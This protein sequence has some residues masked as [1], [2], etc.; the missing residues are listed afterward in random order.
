MPT[1]F[2]L[3]QIKATGF[4]DK[5]F[6]LGFDDWFYTGILSRNRNLFSSQQIGGVIVLS[7]DKRSITWVSLLES[8]IPENGIDIYKLLDYLKEEFSMHTSKSDILEKI[9]DSDLY[10]DKIMEKIYLNYDNYFEEI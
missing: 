8:I 9:E 3:K 7:K 4:K 1:N 10:Y 6:E 5:L 2:T